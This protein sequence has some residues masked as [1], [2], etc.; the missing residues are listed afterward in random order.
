MSCAGQVPEF[1]PLYSGV[2]PSRS[3]YLAFI[4]IVF[5]KMMEITGNFKLPWDGGVHIGGIRKVSAICLKSCFIFVLYHAVHDQKTCRRV[6]A[7]HDNKNVWIGLVTLIS[8]KYTTSTPQTMHSNINTVFSSFSFLASWD[9]VDVIRVLWP[10]N[11][12]FLPLP[13][14][15]LCVAVLCVC[16]CVCMWKDLMWNVEFNWVNVTILGEEEWGQSRKVGE[17]E[18]GEVFGANNRF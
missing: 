18:R 7:V 12:F 8:A 16:E 9:I 17:K 11:T 13:V 2:S 4:C 15:P 1:I 5:L 3:S 10:N 14:A 6:K